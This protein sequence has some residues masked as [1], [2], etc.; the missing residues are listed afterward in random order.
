MADDNEKVKSLI[1][2]SNEIAGGKPAFAH[3]LEKKV[4]KQ[5]TSTIPQTIWG[6]IR[7]VV[8]LAKGGE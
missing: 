5:G 1:R 6:V 8:Q 3:K 4:L 2:T 7:R